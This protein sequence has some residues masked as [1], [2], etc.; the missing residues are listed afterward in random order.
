M[1]TFD[2]IRADQC[3]VEIAQVVVGREAPRKKKGP[4]MKSWKDKLRGLSG[5][6]GHMAA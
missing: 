5:T 6:I 4:E 3:A 1:T 2:E